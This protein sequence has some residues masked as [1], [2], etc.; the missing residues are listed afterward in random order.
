MVYVVGGVQGITYLDNIMFVVCENS[1]AV[2]LYSLDIGSLA[3]DIY[4]HGMGFTSDRM[5][6][7]S[8]I[9][10]CRHDRHLYMADWYCIW[11]VS[12]DDR[13]HVQWLT[14][15]SSTMNFIV[16]SLSVTSQ[17]LLSTSW[18]PC[19]RQHNMAD[20]QTLRVVQLPGY[21]KVLYHGVET[22]RQ[23]FVVGHQGT[24]WDKDQSAVSE[25]FTLCHGLHYSITHSHGSARVL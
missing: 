20:G 13:S 2:R 12:V 25:M 6:S 23:R 17:S 8:D 1:C 5:R 9:V 24:A 14:T 11:R 4:I 10:V 18:P 16:W 22:T 15:E 21:V 19:L 7:P 3:D